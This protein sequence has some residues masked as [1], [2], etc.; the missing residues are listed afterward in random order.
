MSGAEWKF[1][2]TAERFVNVEEGRVSRGP[3]LIGFPPNARRPCRASVSWRFPSMN[4]FEI[5]PLSPDDVPAIGRLFGRVFGEGFSEDDWRWKFERSPFGSCSVVA[6]HS[7]EIV[8]HYGG[9]VWPLAGPRGR[10]D[11]VEICDTMTDPSVRHIGRRTIVARL[12]EAFLDLA[13]PRGI[14]FCFGCPN[15]AARRFGTRRLGYRMLEPLRVASAP[16]ASFGEAGG[17]GVVTSISDQF[18]EGHDRLVAGMNRGPGWHLDRGCAVLN[19]R[20]HARP[21]RYYRVYHVGLSADDPRAFAVVFGVGRLAQVVDL[22]WRSGDPRWLEALLGEIARDLL[23]IGYETL[24]VGLSAGDDLDRLVSGFGFEADDDTNVPSV[25]PI[26]PP[27]IEAMD[28]VAE[29][30]AVRFRWGDFDF[31]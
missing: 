22:Q 13:R 20:Y 7:G 21:G 27:L 28:V 6:L 19:W 16:L 4:E 18:P 15:E 25:G 1:T 17:Q 24:R 11:L 2:M 3:L 10:L 5:R 29:A 31:F 12:Q 8:G 23:P 26:D 30:A 9:F 14:A